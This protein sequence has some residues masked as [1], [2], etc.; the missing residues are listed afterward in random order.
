MSTG[1]RIWTWDRGERE[2]DLADTALVTQVLQTVLEGGLWKELRKFP[3]VAVERALPS[4]RIPSHTR[5]LLELWI[6]EADTEAPPSRPARVAGRR[7]RARRAHTAR[8]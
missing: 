6:E 2:I 1:I 7:G 8:R 4:L 3:P 5:R